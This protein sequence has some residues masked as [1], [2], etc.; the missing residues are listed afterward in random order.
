MLGCIEV[1]GTGEVGHWRFHQVHW[2]SLKGAGEEVGRKPWLAGINSRKLQRSNLPDKVWSFVVLT[3]A[4][5]RVYIRPCML[6]IT[7]A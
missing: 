3:V 5:P 6:I 4:N 7:K 1:G 2:K